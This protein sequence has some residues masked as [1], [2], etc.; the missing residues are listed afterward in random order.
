VAGD[1]ELSG[2]ANGSEMD[3]TGGRQMTS[4]PLHWLL[5]CSLHT[6]WS[7]LAASPECQS[8]FEET[9]AGGGEGGGEERRRSHARPPGSTQS[10]WSSTATRRVAALP[11]WSD[12]PGWGQPFRRRTVTY[13][14]SVHST[15]RPSIAYGRRRRVPENG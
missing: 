6:V 4:P 5:P 3:H 1:A 15:T 2:D 7:Y 11:G 14:L 13:S 8:R 9:G 10:G 12:H